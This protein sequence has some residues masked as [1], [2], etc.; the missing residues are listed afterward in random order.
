MSSINSIDEQYMEHLVTLARNMGHPV[1]L[2]L[3]AL[4]K[5]Y[6]K[7]GNIVMKNT[8][9]YISNQY[10]FKIANAYPDIFEPVNSVHPYRRDAVE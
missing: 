10:V 2:Y 3:L 9:C 8:D 6:D 5:Y 7:S 1:R 4:D